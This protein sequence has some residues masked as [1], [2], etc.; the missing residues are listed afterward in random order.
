MT[1]IAYSM[2]MALR[3]WAKGAL[4]DRTAV[5]ASVVVALGGFTLA[6]HWPLATAVAGAVLILLIAGV[7]SWGE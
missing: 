4:R 5:A 6:W 3:R 7:L 2:T 1:A